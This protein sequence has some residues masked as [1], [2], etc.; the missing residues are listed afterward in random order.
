[1][2]D[3]PIIVAIDT[4][5]ITRA[6][7]LCHNLQGHVGAVKLGLEFFSAHGPDGVR[8][9]LPEG[10]P[11]FLDLKL[12]D[13]PNTVSKAIRSLKGLPVWLLTIHT[14][15]GAAMMEAAAEAADWLAE[16]GQKRPHVLGVTVLTSMDDDDLTDV[17]VKQNVA[18][19]VK[20]LA[21]LAEKSGL[22][23]VVCS[24]KEIE[25]LRDTFAKIEK[26]TN[27]HMLL[28]TPGIRP[29]G[30]DMG[31]Q[32]RAMTPKQALEAGAD[33][34][35]IGRPITQADDPVQVAQNLEIA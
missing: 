8:K 25:L 9:A 5:D 13:I 12:Y 1:M 3:N 30:S 18:K 29:V 16:Q 28:V 19:Q 7:T 6:S 20:Q 26:E 21:L 10:M 34:L 11:L 32:K 31:D 27:K 24:P 15:G 2:A 4:P 33:Y 35:V 22:D 23:G 14:S 17:G